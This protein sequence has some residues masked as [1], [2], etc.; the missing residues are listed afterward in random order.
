[1]KVLYIQPFWP[2]PIVYG[3]EMRSR[4]FVDYLAKRSELDLFIPMKISNETDW[5]Y[6]KAKFRSCHYADSI[7]SMNYWEKFAMLLPWQLAQFYSHESQ[8]KLERLVEK[9]DYDL[10]FLNKLYSVP[11]LFK[12]PEKWYARIVVDF[13]DILSD[14]YRRSYKEFFT[15]HKNSI[16][17]KINEE[18]ALKSFQ[19]VFI[20]AEEA[21]SKI[22][23]RFHEK[24]GII[25]NVFNV[26]ERN[27]LA[28]PPDRNR[29]LFVGSLDYP[30]NMEGLNWFLRDIWPA[31][32]AQC[33]GLRLTVIG[34]FQN[35]IERLYAHLNDHPDVTVEVN[36]PDVR[37]YYRESYASIVPLLNGSGTRLKILES[38][39]YGRPVL[40]TIK[41]MEGLEFKDKQDIF[42]FQ[43][44]QS[45]CDAYQAVGNPEIYERVRD[46]GYRVLTD[47]YSPEAFERSMD[48]NWKLIAGRN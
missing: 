33:P 9:E 11:Y 14:L 12:L 29:L 18:K 4:R 1:M 34:K 47:R 36:V 3:G 26:N 20:C 44:A 39:A 48:E 21:L 43:D 15:S 24:I 5:D 38:Y 7:G 17:L 19:R 42:V 28:Q 6:I 25:P 35:K 8:Q 27:R 16:F 32:K 45:F 30:P 40:T 2:I 22:N 23:P 46:A 13:D 10:I 41:G 31:V 37:P